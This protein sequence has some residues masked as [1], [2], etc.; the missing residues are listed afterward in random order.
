MGLLSKAIAARW[1]PAA[2]MLWL[3][4]AFAQ[5]TRQPTSGAAPPTPSDIPPGLADVGSLVDLELYESALRL[6]DQLDTRPDRWTDAHTRLLVAAV[7]GAADD[8]LYCGNAAAAARRY[9]WLAERFASLDPQRVARWRSRETV[10]REQAG[11]PTS[12]P[13]HA[14]PR[15]RA[16]R[17]QV[18]VGQE[19]RVRRHRLFLVY[20]R[21]D[22]A[23]GMV[24]QAADFHLAQICT[25]LSVDPEAIAWP[26]PVRIYL[27]PTRQELRRAAG[28]AGRTLG[29]SVIRIANA[30]T[31]DQVVH[32]SQ[33]APL[34]LSSVLPHELAH[35]LI[36]HS[37]GYRPVPPYLDEGLAL[38]FEPPAVQL[39]YDRIETAINQVPTCAA[40]IAGPA[41][42]T[43]RRES[44]YALARILADFLIQRLGMPVLLQA[45][46]R[47][48]DLSAALVELGPWEGIGELEEDWSRLAR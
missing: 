24:E 8:H 37:A 17:W 48:Q 29:R 30:E 33:D 45:C 23:A 10:A 21:N 11:G 4:A 43:P 35:L 40:L 32:L 26:A 1:L 47:E 27:H 34:L 2:L 41:P 9:G 3:P 19:W 42:P 31:S 14:L 20:H 22:F 12:R 25:F 7:E 6:L 15:R 44:D 18:V 28:A 5:P 16:G 36:A 13:A 39:R 38:Q 46:S